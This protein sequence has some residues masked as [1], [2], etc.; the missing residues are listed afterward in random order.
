MAM[1]A[2]A[3]IISAVVGKTNNSVGRI[4]LQFN[5]RMLL[6]EPALT[7]NLVHYFLSIASNHKDLRFFQKNYRGILREINVPF[8]CAKSDGLISP[9]LFLFHTWFRS[10]SFSNDLIFL[11]RDAG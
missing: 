6:R 10:S 9:S 1:D 11:G 5:T 2:D 3:V 7:E 4:H 8:A